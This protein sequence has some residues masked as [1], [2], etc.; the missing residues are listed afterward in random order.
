MKGFLNAIKSFFKIIGIILL[1][2]TLIFGV[3][4]AYYYFLAPDIIKTFDQ[5]GGVCFDYTLEEHNYADKL[6]YKQLNES[7]A[8]HYRCMYHAAIN[9][10]T[11]YYLQTSSLFESDDAG[12]AVRAFDADFPE[13]YWFGQI[14]STEAT[15]K[16]DKLNLF[17][18]YF[19]KVE[20]ECHDFTE[21][22]ILINQEIIDTKLNEILPSLIGEDDYS[23]I[24]N[25]YDYIASNVEYDAS[26]VDTSDIRA[27]FINE[28]GVCSSYSET[29]QMICNRLGY[30]CYSVQGDGLTLYVGDEI[31]NSVVEQIASGDMGHEWNI[32]KIN[33]SWYWV[34]PTWGDGDTEYEDLYG[35][36]ITRVDYSYLLVPDSIFLLDHTCGDTFEYPKCEDESYYLYDESGVII[37]EY[38][39][40]L[41]NS[42]IAS[43][44]FNRR[45]DYTFHFKSIE[46]VDSFTNWIER[47][48]F[49]NVYQN[50]ISE[51]YDGRMNYYISN[52]CSVHLNWRITNLY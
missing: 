26:M 21:E 52:N 46:D 11:S 32:I 34:D 30:E 42:S 4:I 28:K 27:A 44:F 33:E 3:L 38:D 8:R 22:D 41:I 25:V 16:K 36:N 1:I 10:E 39:Q 6:H 14:I 5:Y 18:F 23:T 12:R 7:E 24:K 15:S 20:A 9:N 50:N 40:D 45:N 43:A 2:I 31:E 37:D 17:D 13:F 47:K 35:N 29:F 19:V 49:Y 48:G 51:Y